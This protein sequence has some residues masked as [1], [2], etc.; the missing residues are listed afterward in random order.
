MTMPPQEPGWSQPVAGNQ[1]G[2]PLQWQE[3]QAGAGGVFAP[4]GAV[5]PANAPLPPPPERDNSGIWPFIVGTIVVLAG[6]TLVVVLAGSGTPTNS[7]TVNPTTVVTTTQLA[8]AIIVK[9]GTTS[10]TEDGTPATTPNKAAPEG[11]TTTSTP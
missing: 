6:I 9:P 4:V 11:E 10:P 7:V 3:A 2:S 5:S 1:P 8:P